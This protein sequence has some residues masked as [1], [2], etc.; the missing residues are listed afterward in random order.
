MSVG[1]GWLAVALA[2][3]P[4]CSV[5]SALGHSWRQVPHLVVRYGLGW[6]WCSPLTS[7]GLLSMLLSEKRHW[8]EH[9]TKVLQHS[10]RFVPSVKMFI[11]SVKPRSSFSLLG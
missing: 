9:S 3:I 8:H 4:R 7:T 1:I 6:C 5:T 2:S 10:N 11:V